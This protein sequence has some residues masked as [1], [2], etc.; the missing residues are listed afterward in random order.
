MSTGIAE[1]DYRSFVVSGGKVD[2]PFHESSLLYNPHEPDFPE[3][4]YYC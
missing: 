3:T 2:A 1:T 4:Q